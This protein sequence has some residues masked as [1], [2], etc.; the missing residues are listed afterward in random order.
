MV[1]I[2]IYD[3]YEPLVNGLMDEGALFDSDFWLINWIPIYWVFFFVSKV[4]AK[5]ACDP[6]NYRPNENSAGHILNNW[7]W[8]FK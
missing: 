4:Q 6:K 7:F 1:E 2:Y 5:M 8:V 3:D